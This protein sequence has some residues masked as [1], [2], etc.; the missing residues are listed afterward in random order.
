MLLTWTKSGTKEKNVLRTVSRIATGF[1]PVGFTSY[2][3]H[4]VG[5]ISYG[6]NIL[7]GF[8]S[9]SYFSKIMILNPPFNLQDT[10][11]FEG[12]PPKA[13]LRRF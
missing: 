5:Y 8:V 12:K 2:G 13:A 3:V 6:V 4:P 1:D 7:S 10:M 9:T 11:L